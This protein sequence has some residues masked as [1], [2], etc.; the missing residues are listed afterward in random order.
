MVQTSSLDG[1]GFTSASDLEHLLPLF[2]FFRNHDFRNKKIAKQIVN[3]YNLG[4]PPPV[5]H[6]P[7]PSKSQ[8]AAFF[9]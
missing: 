1:G 9:A 4:R 6:P 8:V 3:F 2:I 7:A 5:S